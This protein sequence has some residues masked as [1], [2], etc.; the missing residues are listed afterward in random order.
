MDTEKMIRELRAVAAKHAD[1]QV[2]TGQLSISQ[3]C[4]DVADRLEEQEY[5][6]NNMS[7]TE[8]MHICGMPFE[9]NW[10]RSANRSTFNTSEGIYWINYT[11]PFEGHDRKG[12]LYFVSF[13]SGNSTLIADGFIECELMTMAYNNAISMYKNKLLTRMHDEKNS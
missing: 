7:S 13:E 10:T 4:Q 2:F 9:N 6:I 12:T 8:M 1:D 11:N 5:L 3:M